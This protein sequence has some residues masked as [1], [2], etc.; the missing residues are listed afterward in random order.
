MSD[1]KYDS[2]MKE[3]EQ[4]RKLLLELYHK[5]QKFLPSF[6]FHL[7]F[8]GILD[9]LPLLSTKDMDQCIKN[10]IP[11]DGA[12]S[13]LQC[14]IGGKYKALPQ[15]SDDIENIQT[16]FLRDKS[17]INEG[18]KFGLMVQSSIELNGK[19][20]A[21]VVKIPK[22][23]SGET[24][25]EAFVNFY[26]INRFVKTIHDLG[27]D[28]AQLVSSYGFFTCKQQKWTT[29]CY[30][31]CVINNKN[32]RDSNCYLYLIQQYIPAISLG[33]YLLDIKINQNE[34]L[35]IMIKIFR[36][37]DI[38]QKS[39]F[40]VNHMDLHSGNILVGVGDDRKWNGKVWIIDWARASFTYENKRFENTFVED[41]YTDFF[42][43]DTVI[44]D[45]EY[46]YPKPEFEIN[47][48][49]NDFNR[50]M[51]MP[52]HG[53]I[54]KIRIDLLTSLFPEPEY[55]DF[56]KKSSE[57]LNIWEIARDGEIDKRMIIVNTMKDWTYAKILI[58]LQR[59]THFARSSD[60]IL[61]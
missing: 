19:E 51:F 2:S 30:E 8:Q 35:K 11:D 9:S 57:F 20:E 21:V 52:L 17:K 28:Y 1:E 53:G 27:Y 39:E 37:L 18:G 33:E 38:L 34:I 47:G 3:M 60:C 56:I 12:P 25:L 10:R 5:N 46:S 45:G 22:K 36:T 13:F 50:I 49:L 55:Q 16:L 48:T 58:Y 29:P 44:I 31:P 6:D 32:V 43:A 15:T 7:L 41:F 61:F 59:D 26:I 24:I 14:K 42:E 4:Q 40:K 23:W 54:N